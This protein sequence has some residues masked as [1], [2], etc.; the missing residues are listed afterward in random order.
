M[1]N[2]R[3]CMHQGGSEATFL[4]LF[5]IVFIVLIVLICIHLYPYVSISVLDI[6][7]WHNT[8]LM[9]HGF[10][11][12]IIRTIRKSSP[13]VSPHML[14]CD[15]ANVYRPGIQIH[16][17]A[18]ENRIHRK[19]HV[20]TASLGMVNVVHAVMYPRPQYDA[21]ILAMDL[22]AVNEVPT[23]GIVDACPVT[24]ELRLPREYEGPMLDLQ[25]KYGLASVPRAAMPDW[26]REIF[27][28][29]CIIQRAPIDSPAFR[30]YA[31]DLLALHLEYCSILEP[32]TY[33]RRIRKNH[34]RFCRMQLKNW[35]TRSALASAL[36]GDLT[37]A[38][39]Y[40]NRVMFDC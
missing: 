13:D 7:L 4:H 21:P 27:S 31:L 38:N 15:L 40:M 11:R 28:D 35:K 23:F 12:D 1:R 30:A 2:G 18:F 6:S 10:G 25:K 32:S 9:M 34:S 14:P 39:E 19:L 20:E 17:T 22:V 24:D 29:A 26:G 5:F 3:R 8:F 33:H 16:N 37:F 36:G